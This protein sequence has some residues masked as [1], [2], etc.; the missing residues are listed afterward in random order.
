MRA[1]FLV[2][3][4]EVVEQFGWV[5]LLGV[6]GRLCGVGCGGVLGFGGLRIR[7]L[8]VCLLSGVSAQSGVIVGDALVDGCADVNL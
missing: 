3:E 4:D 2:A 1:G 6:L 7:C 8:W 5:G